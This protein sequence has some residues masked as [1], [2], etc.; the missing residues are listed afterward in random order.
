MVFSTLLYEHKFTS[1]E[2]EIDM[3]IMFL[4]SYDIP[5]SEC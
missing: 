2:C 4:Q 1:L 5:A 3:Q